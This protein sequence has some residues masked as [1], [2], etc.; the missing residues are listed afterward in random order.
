MRS[1]SCDWGYLLRL[2]DIYPL[3]VPIKGGHSKWIPEVII[4]TAPCLPEDMFK[5]HQNDQVWDKIDQ[6]KRRITVYRNFNEEPYNPTPSA[7]ED[8]SS[9]TI[10]DEL[11]RSFHTETSGLPQWL[12]PSQLE[13][14][15]Q[16]RIQGSQD[17]NMDFLLQKK[18][19]ILASLHRKSTIVERTE[20]K[21]IK[22][23]S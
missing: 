8:D 3:T 23:F 1:N 16:L 5:N 7:S 9:S 22:L 11:L 19:L 15:A 4:I 10:D 21:I 14:I 12:S 18:W 17:Y 20:M 2:L 6:L 13:L